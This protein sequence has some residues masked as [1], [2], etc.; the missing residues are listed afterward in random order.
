MF[1]R[2]VVRKINEQINCY[3][4][5]LITLNTKIHNKK[6]NIN[7]MITAQSIF[8][9]LKKQMPIP[10]LDEEKLKKTVSW[11]RVHSNE[12]DYC[13]RQMNRTTMVLKSMGYDVLILESNKL[14]C[15]LYEDSVQVLTEAGRNDFR[16]LPS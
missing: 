6:L 1:R 10:L 4:G 8:D 7:D 15:I 14:E 11:L 12:F 3:Q 16:V 13:V 2:Y 9:E 5:I